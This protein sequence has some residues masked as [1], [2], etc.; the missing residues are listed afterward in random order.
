[1]TAAT[2]AVEL[3]TWPM[4]RRRPVTSAAPARTR[5][6]STTMYAMGKKV[7]TPP[8]TSVRT[9]DPRSS[10]WKYRVSPVVVRVPARCSTGLSYPGGTRLVLKGLWARGCASAASPVNIRDT[11]L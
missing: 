10:T 11:Y 4:S 5:G 6:L 1:M 9:V 8:R 7:A 3:A 2:R